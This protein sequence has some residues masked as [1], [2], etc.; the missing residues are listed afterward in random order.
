[1]NT[2]QRHSLDVL[3]AEDDAISA[4]YLTDALTALGCRVQHHAN[5]A[6]ALAAAH[7]Q[8]FDLLLLDQQLPE[9][10][11]MQILAAL[12]ADHAAASHGSPMI[13]TCAGLDPAQHARLL[14]A[15]FDDALAKPLGLDRLRATLAA[16]HNSEGVRLD[17]AQGLA[18]SGCAATL[19]ALRGLLLAELADCAMQF[20]TQLEHH[21]Q[22]L[23]ARLHRLRASCGFCGATQLQQ[24]AAALHDALGAAHVDDALVSHFRALL[25]ATRISL[26][27]AGARAPDLPATTP[28]AAFRPVVR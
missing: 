13:A 9:C 4:L 15:G 2:A 7:A 27:R 17:E 8:R 22:A 28:S 21:P 25:A 14:A 24:A 26:R 16:V 10:S 20:D 6:A 12:Q 19:T 23:R 3:L 5:G 18:A 1:M 11:G